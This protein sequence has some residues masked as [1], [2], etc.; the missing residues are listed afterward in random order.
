VFGPR[1]KNLEAYDLFVRARVLSMLSADGNR[2]S[3]PLLERAIAIEPDFADAHAWL[4]MAHHFGWLYW[5]EP[6][7]THRALARSSAAQAVAL[8]P[9]NAD[10][11]WIN[12]YVKAYDGDL[13]AGVE[14]FAA[15]L[16]INPNHADAWALLTDLKVL[17]GMPGEAVECAR[18]AF[19]LNPYPPAVY[20][21]VMGWGLY[22][23]GRY[24]E[25]LESLRHDASRGTGARRLI[26]ATL[27]RLGRLE[28]ARAEARLFLAAIP[29][30]STK[31]WA[32]TQPF[33]RDVDRQH[34]IDGCLKAG[35]PD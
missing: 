11:R 3:R 35:L 20:Y 28:E 27:A 13:P 2:V 8:G 32:R 4:A 26:A 16:R 25:A 33:L 5:G 6:E 9:D 19:R 23:A 1:A 34:F 21:W 24:E 31:A 22:A 29:H 10:A 18:N 7:E 15:A 12:G 30:F 17:L 14:E